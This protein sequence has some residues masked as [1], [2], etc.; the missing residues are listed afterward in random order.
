MKNSTSP[1][2]KILVVLGVVVIGLGIWYWF[3]YKQTTSNSVSGE[4]DNNVQAPTEKDELDGTSW[5][6]TEYQV[7]F[8]TEKKKM[9]DEA[10]VTAKFS[11]SKVSGKS[12]CNNY[13]GT[14]QVNGNEIS[15]GPIASTRMACEGFAQ[16][17]ET[18]YLGQLQKVKY[19]D[20]QG[21]ALYLRDA[22]KNVVLS[23]ENL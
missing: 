1:L 13:N 18:T 2:Q 22:D 3:N 23:F 19:Y 20:L 17:I 5:K 16:E 12:G 14:Y 11:D 8:G 7:A 10:E 9:T 21:N 15:F 4:P 6:L